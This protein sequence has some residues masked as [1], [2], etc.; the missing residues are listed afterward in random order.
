[1]GEKGLVG[2]LQLGLEL[3]PVMGL[4]V[5]HNMLQDHDFQHFLGLGWGNIHW[6]MR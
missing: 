6:E 2:E 5:L 4:M 3:D 1:M